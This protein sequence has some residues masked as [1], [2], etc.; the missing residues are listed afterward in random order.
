MLAALKWRN[1]Q[2]DELLFGPRDRDLLS[3]VSMIG[4]RINNFKK[5]TLI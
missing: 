1:S 3:P 2:G 5:V 4:E